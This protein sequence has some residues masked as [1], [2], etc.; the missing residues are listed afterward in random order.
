MS[1]GAVQI[2]F[3]ALAMTEVMK[4]I[5]HIGKHFKSVGGRILKFSS[6]EFSVEVFTVRVRYCTIPSYLSVFGATGAW[7]AF[8]NFNV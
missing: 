2:A 6:W 5:G 1:P 3:F 7:R 4:L 8:L